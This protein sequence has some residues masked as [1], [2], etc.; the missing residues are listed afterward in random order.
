MWCPS[1]ISLPAPFG[2]RRG[3]IRRDA[4][5]VGTHYP[6]LWTFPMPHA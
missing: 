6:T 3:P 1:G 5:R 4:T 2:L